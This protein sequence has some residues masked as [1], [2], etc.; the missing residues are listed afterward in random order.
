MRE[1]LLYA[2]TAPTADFRIDDLPSAG[3]ID[4]VCRC[5][6][7]CMFVSEKLRDDVV[8]HIS[9]GG[10]PDPPKL[11]TVIPSELKSIYPDEKTIALKIRDALIGSVEGM[12]VK[13]QSFESFVKERGRI[14]Q[15]IYLHKKGE[16]IREVELKD[17]L[18]IVGDHKGIPKKTEKLLER[19]GAK[20]ISLGPVTYLSSQCITLLQNE[21]DRRLYDKG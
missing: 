7:N 8:F 13:K 17:S 4:L 9:L 2:R 19:L 16:D 5:L 6:I 20:K 1:F 3:R 21:L 15:L 10:P 12:V 14:K 18:F 11:L